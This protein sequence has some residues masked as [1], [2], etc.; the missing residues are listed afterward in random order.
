VMTD[1][2]MPGMDGSELARS[3]RRNPRWDSVK[4]VAVTADTEV[5]HSFN[6]KHFDDVLLKPLTLKKILAFF[7]KLYLPEAEEAEEE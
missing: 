6:M 1:V 3:I 4:I 7:H 5:G 2:W